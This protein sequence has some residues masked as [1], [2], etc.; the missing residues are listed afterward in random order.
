MPAPDAESAPAHPRSNASD[1]LRQIALEQFAAVGFA[2]A[3]LQQIADEAGYSKSSVL[4]HY[5][6]KEALLEAAI[7][8]AIDRLGALLQR[9]TERGP[10]VEARTLFVEEFIDFLLEHRLEV[11]TFVNQGHSLSGIPV[12]DRANEFIVTLSHTVCNDN[13]STEDKMRFGM[14]LGGAAYSLVAGMSFLDA[15]SL[16]PVDE[17]RAALIRLI[18]ELLAPVTIPTA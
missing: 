15:D 7:G 9:Y 18:G 4:Y 6:N 17:V 5:A 2:G 13:A 10:T 14:A 8:P 12:I 16:G 3:S 11:Y 1:D